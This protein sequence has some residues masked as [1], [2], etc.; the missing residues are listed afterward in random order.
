MDSQKLAQENADLRAR[1]AELE[2]IQER[3][4]AAYGRLARW[5]GDF[6]DAYTSG[7]GGR[8][9]ADGDKPV[10]VKEVLEPVRPHPWAPLQKG[11]PWAELA[12]LV[13]PVHTDW[14]AKARAQQAEYLAGW[15][16]A[17]TFT[18]N[19]LGVL[20]KVAN[21][22][23][24]WYSSGGGG[25]GYDSDLT[26]S[27]RRAFHGLRKARVV[28]HTPGGRYTQSVCALTKPPVQGD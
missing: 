3:Q 19:Q 11:L 7:G 4:D 17:R 14:V 5:L 21:L 25:L 2:A 16:A 20:E 1:I 8:T 23:Q 27:E 9:S 10:Q 15:K 12:D 26:D 18:A 28:S 13:T 22:D 24:V 6:Q